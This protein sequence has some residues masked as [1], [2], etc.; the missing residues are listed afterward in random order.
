MQ[1]RSVG[2][3]RG[4]WQPPTCWDRMVQIE[5]VGPDWFEFQYRYSK[6]KG[7][8]ATWV[9]LDATFQLQAA[10]SR[11]IW[12]PKLPNTRHAVSGRSHR[13]GRWDRRSR[14]RREI[15][16]DGLIEA[17]GLKGTRRGGCFISEKH[18]NF[19]MNDGNGNVSGFQSADPAG[20]R[21]S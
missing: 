3:F 12:R 16:Q 13:V 10:R 6:L 21:R 15:T 8:G 1:V 9:V 5:T 18:A 2:R 19:L 7:T 20:A 11:R 14:I 4:F 17:A